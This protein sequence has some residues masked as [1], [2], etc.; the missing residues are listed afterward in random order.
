MYCEKEA[1]WSHLLKFTFQTWLGAG[2]PLLELTAQLPVTPWAG[3]I[4]GQVS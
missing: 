2:G 1:V 4:T 3:P